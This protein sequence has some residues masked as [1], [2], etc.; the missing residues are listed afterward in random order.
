MIQIITIIGAIWVLKWVLDP[1]SKN[2]SGISIEV[3]ADR[4]AKYPFPYHQ[5]IL[6]TA[7]RLGLDPDLIASIIYVESGGRNVVGD[8]GKSFGLMQI[9][10]GTA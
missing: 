5:L 8:Q 3:P 6:S 4:N 2:E 10:Y 7:R 9:Q 1:V